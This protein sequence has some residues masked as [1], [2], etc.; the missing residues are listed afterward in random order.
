[1]RRFAFGL[2]FAM[3]GAGT[4]QF[5]AVVA[6]DRPVSAVR[7]GDEGT[8]PRA[9]GAPSQSHRE[10]LRGRR[11]RPSQV[12]GALEKVAQPLSGHAITHIM[13]NRRILINPMSSDAA[14]AGPSFA[15][16]FCFDQAR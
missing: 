16:S 4:A 8:E 9:C 14:A 15:G 1:M 10:R 13:I 7:I 5:S 6:F 3:E 12:G 2:S 11:A